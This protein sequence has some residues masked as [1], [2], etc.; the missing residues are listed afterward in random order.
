MTVALWSL[1]AYAL[2]T[3]LLQGIGLTRGPDVAGSAVASADAERLRR[4]ALARR[5][6]VEG[7]PVFG[8]V[9]MVSDQ[10]GLLHPAIDALALAVVVLR[11]LQSFVYLAGADAARSPLTVLQILAILGMAGTEIG[12]WVAEH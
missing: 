1:L 11:V 5:D 2:W 4:L 8:T 9:V 3:A 12:L 7:L 10:G 6:C